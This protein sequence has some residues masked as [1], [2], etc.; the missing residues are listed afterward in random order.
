VFMAVVLVQF[1]SRMK[2]SPAKVS[3]DATAPGG[4]QSTHRCCE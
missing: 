3:N 1:F 2:K 4:K